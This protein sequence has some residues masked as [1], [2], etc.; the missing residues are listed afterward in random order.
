MIMPETFDLILHNINLATM[1]ED[2]SYGILENA[3]VCIKDGTIH[4]IFSASDPAI[5]QLET[6]ESMD[7]QGQWVTPGLIDCHT[8]LIYGGDRSNEFEMRLNGASYEEIANNGGGIVSTVDATRAS[9]KDEL[10]NSAAKRLSYLIDEGVTTIEIKSGYGL[11][12]ET[13]KKMLEVAE[14]LEKYSSVQ[15]SKTF[16]GAHAVPKEYKGRADDY[17]DLV[18][19]TMLPNLNQLGLIDCVDAFC[20]SIGFNLEQTQRV[21][22]AAIELKLPVKLHAE[23]LS[24]LGG[25]KLASELGAW[26]VDHLEFLS[27][28]VAPILKESGTV[29]TLL[30]GA[31][32]F[33][34]EKKL[35]PISAL[36]KNNVPIAIA[37]DCNPGSSPCLSLLLMLNMATTLFKLT[38]LEALRGVTINAAKALR[39]DSKIGSIEIGKQADLALWDIRSPAEL[40]YRIGGNPCTAVIKKGK[41]VLNKNA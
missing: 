29:A 35:P 8:H 14:E 11:D 26:S 38:P 1:A 30:P 19:T 15:V 28:D 9:S 23:Q 20:E 18:C 2:D 24:D 34:S 40:S 36:R 7:G 33:L 13:E 4:A 12:F 41:V 16:L 6:E 32:Y 10:F 17:I 5:K 3:V 37:T 31:F 25:S 27:P 22:D 21:F 39:R